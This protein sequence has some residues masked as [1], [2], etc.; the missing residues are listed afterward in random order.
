MTSS[1]SFG[2]SSINTG[3]NTGSSGTKLTEKTKKNLEKLGVDTSNIKT[4]TEGQ[5]KLKEVQAS[6]NSQATQQGQAAQQQQQAGG[7]SS[8]QTLMTEVKS[9]AA[10]ANVDVSSSDKIDDVFSKISKKITEMKAEAQ[11]DETKKGQASAYQA[12][13]D[14]LYAQY[15]KQNMLS[16]AMNGLANYNK[17]ALGL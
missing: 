2:S 1:V 11:N 13:Y 17:A 14:E 10:S 8:Q 4:E 9:L 5:Q 3:I 7:A 6:Q 15:Q 16:S 12:K